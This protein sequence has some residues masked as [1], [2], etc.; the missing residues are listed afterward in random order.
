MTTGA[1]QGHITVA[2]TNWLAL[3]DDGNYEQSWNEAS[4]LIPHA[5]DP[6]AMGKRSQGGS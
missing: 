2:A 5:R 1:D 4:T 6:G 3:V